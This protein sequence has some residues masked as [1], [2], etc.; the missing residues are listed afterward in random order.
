MGNKSKKVE[1]KPKKCD[2]APGSGACKKQKTRGSLT[3]RDCK[4]C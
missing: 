4:A 1:G 2:N 3:C